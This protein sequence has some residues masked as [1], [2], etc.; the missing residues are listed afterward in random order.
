MTSE[1]QFVCYVGLWRLAGN[2]LATENQP[3]SIS[4]DSI[5]EEGEAN[6]SV[7]AIAGAMY[8]L[9]TIA[10]ADLWGGCGLCL[11]GLGTR[12]GFMWFTRRRAFGAG[13]VVTFFTLFGAS[14]KVLFYSSFE[15]V[16]LVMGSA[17]VLFIADVV[18]FPGY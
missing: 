17:A 16:E 1:T 3:S 8:L 7:L 18:S 14:V 10:A 5:S 2:Q 9:L 11:E 6:Y 4:G 15:N 13:L 12:D